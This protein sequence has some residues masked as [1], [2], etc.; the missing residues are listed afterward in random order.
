MENQLHKTVLVNFRISSAT[1]EPFDHSCTLAGKTRT[2]VITEL[3]AGYTAD[4]ASNV[5]NQFDQR[6]AIARTLRKAVL[7]ASQMKLEDCPPPMRLAS[8]K[9]LKRKFSSF[10]GLASNGTVQP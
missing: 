10:L 6:A 4:T 8:E 2:Q 9:R 1:L 7:K 5:Q 3:M